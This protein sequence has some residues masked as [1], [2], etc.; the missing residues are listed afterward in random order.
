MFAQDDAAPEE[1]VVTAIMR[2]ESL[3]DAPISITVVSD[4]DVQSS[5]VTCACFFS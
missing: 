5:G 4:E 1:I 2:N 3:Q